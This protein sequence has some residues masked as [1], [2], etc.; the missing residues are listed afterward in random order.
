MA[1]KKNKKQ[2]NKKK[3]M[4]VIYI[5]RVQIYQYIF[6]HTYDEMYFTNG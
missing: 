4:Y 5:K 1:G 6:I 3:H 2:K